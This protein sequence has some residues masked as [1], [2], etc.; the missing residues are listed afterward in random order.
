M[1]VLANSYGSA[2]GVAVL[3]P[4]HN[5]GAGTFDANTNPTITTTETLIDQVSATINAILS[6]QGFAIPVSQTDAALMLTGFVNQEVAA[7]VE[8]INGIGR[9]GPTAKTPGKGRFGLLFEDIRDFVESIATGLEFLGAT[10]TYSIM[11]GIA[12]RDTDNSGAEISPIFQREAF[13]NVF[14]EWDPD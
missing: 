7:L 1:T 8:G 10:R 4:R 11:D 2:A 12:Y 9:F 14:K 6:Q 13:G 3:V 5:N